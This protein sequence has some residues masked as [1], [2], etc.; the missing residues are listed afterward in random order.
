MNKSQPYFNLFA[1]IFTLACATSTAGAAPSA[2]DLYQKHCAICHGANGDGRGRITTGMTP[3]PRDFTSELSTV[4]LSRDRIIK[5]IRD[6][7][8]GTSMTGWKQKLSNR[9]IVILADFITDSFIKPAKAKRHSSLPPALVQ[10]LKTG[11]KIYTEFCSVCHGDY[12][13]TGVWTQANMASAPRN[14]TSDRSRSNLARNRMIE[15]V[16]FGVPGKAMMPFASRLSPTEIESVV[17]YIRIE[18]MA[19]PLSESLQEFNASSDKAGN[20]T[21]GILN[22][23]DHMKK[24]YP[25]GMKGDP[26][27]GRK[28]FVR[29]CF[30]CHGVNGDGKGPR[31]FFINPKP[32][33]F[34][35]ADSKRALNRPRIFKAVNNGLP[36]SVMP[37]WGKV[38]NQQQVTDVSEFVFRAFI[39]GDMRGVSQNDLSTDPQKKN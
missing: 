29:N 9:E 18:L 5:S 15:A 6:G 17:D 33:N 23:A 2:T 32:R 21:P 37:A 16:S 24:P 10:R 14:F 35:S 8:P 26:N 31:A 19:M 4:N 25:G 39:V 13:Q 22:S 7:N 12:G 3:P 28:L 36:G 27:E 38:F 34:I 30:P 1:T 20:Q 11:E